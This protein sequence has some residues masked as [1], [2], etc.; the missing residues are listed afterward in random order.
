[1]RI[2]WS[3]TWKCLSFQQQK[4]RDVGRVLRSLVGDPWQV[5]VSHQAHPYAILTHPTSQ[6]AFLDALGEHSQDAA[7]PLK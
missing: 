7:Q 6:K 2:L 4:K 5:L 1:M 3:M